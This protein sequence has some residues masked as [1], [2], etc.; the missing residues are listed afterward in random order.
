MFKRKYNRL[1]KSSYFPLVSNALLS[2]EMMLLL[3][4]SNNKIIPIL[5]ASNKM[6]I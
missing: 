1:Y 5:V 2:N 6:V 3:A 4:A